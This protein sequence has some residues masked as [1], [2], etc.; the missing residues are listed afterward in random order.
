MRK[1]YSL[2]APLLFI[3]SMLLFSLNA[4][5]TGS[6]S[7]SWGDAKPD[8][9][10]M[11]SG[12]V[13]ATN[14]NV[15]REGG[16]CGKNAS[17]RLEGGCFLNSDK[18]LQNIPI[19]N[20][21]SNINETARV[22]MLAGNDAP[23]FNGHKNRT[24]TPLEKCRVELWHTGD[25]GSGGT[26][27]RNYKVKQTASI[28]HP[29]DKN[30]VSPTNEN[31]GLLYRVNASVRTTDGLADALS[32]SN[33]ITW[34]A[35][36]PTICDFDSTDVNSAWV[37]NNP[38]QGGNKCKVQ[39]S[40]SGNNDLHGPI[41]ATQEW[42]IINTK[43]P[44]LELIAAPSTGKKPY[45]TYS[46]S[47]PSL[48]NNVRV[49]PTEG[50]EDST[51]QGCG[52]PV[53]TAAAGLNKFVFNELT[54]GQSYTCT[55]EVENTNGT[56]ELILPEFKV[57]PSYDGPGGVGGADGTTGTVLW[58]KGGEWQ[59][60]DNRI[61]T[62]LDSTG[63]ANDFKE[64]SG[65]GSASSPFSSLGAAYA[66]VQQGLIA[67]NSI[68]S[69]FIAG[70]AFTTYVDSNGYVLVAS[71]LRGSPPPNSGYPETNS[72]QP[73]NA[74][75]LKREI[76]A[77][78]D[79]EEVRIS[80]LED[81]GR[82]TLD[83]FSKTAKTI[84]KLKLFQTLPNNNESGGWTATLGTNH[85]LG[86][87][88][89]PGTNEGQTER[90]LNQEIY[91]A[92]GIAGGLHW[93][94]SRPNEALTYPNNPGTY[95]DSLDLWVRSTTLPE[96][97]PT[98]GTLAGL[99]I[100]AFENGQAL[101]LSK[102]L[103]MRSLFIVYKNE[104]TSASSTPFMS[105]TGG[106]I[107]GADTASGLTHPSKTGDNVLNGKNYSAG[108]DIGNATTTP[109]PTSYGLFSHILSANAN[110]SGWTLGRDGNFIGRG[111][112][113][114]IAEVIVTD[115]AV[116]KAER[117]IIENY[118]AIKFGLQA[119]L[120]GDS[121]AARYT[122]ADYKY[123][124]GGIGQADDSSSTMR[125]KS[126]IIEMSGS[127]SGTNRFLMWGHNNAP[128]AFQTT[129]VPVAE[130][131]TSRLSRT[132]KVANTG[133]GAID[134]TV[135]LREIPG[136][137]SMC[138]KGGNFVLLVSA[139]GSFANATKVTG[140]FDPSTQTIAFPNVTLGDN[141]YFT[142]GAGGAGAE[143]FVK[144]VASGKKDGSTWANACS[145]DGAFNAPR[146]AG[147]TIKLAKGVY[148]PSSTYN[149]T[150]AITVE[151]GYAGL[152]VGEGADPAANKTIISG[153]VDRNDNTTD[154]EVMYHRE[155]NGNNL[156]RLFNI[157]NVHGV[158]NSVSLDGFTIT[159]MSQFTNHGAAVWQ[160]N[161][162][163]N[164][165]NMRFLGNRARG[166][167]GAI[168]VNGS[169]AQANISNSL[170]RGNAS[171]HGG[172]IA[173]R[174]NAK[175]T[176][177][178]SEFF[179]NQA[180]ILV[181]KDLS[182]TGSAM[183]FGANTN[184]NLANTPPSNNFTV[185]LWVKP[186]GTIA[187]KNVQNTGVEGISGDQRYVFGA[188]HGGANNFGMG[189]SIGTNGI[190][191]A[192]HGDG[193]IP[194]V[195]K[196]LADLS[197]WNHVAIVYTK[198]GSN[199]P[200]AQIYLNGAAVGSSVISS[201]AT[202]FAPVQMGSAASYQHPEGFVGEVDEVRIWNKSLTPA[203]VAN[204]YY[205]TIDSPQTTANLVGYWQFEGNVQDSSSAASSSNGMGL[206]YVNT[207]IIAAGA[208]GWN[209]YE[210]GAIDI[211]DKA[212]VTINSSLFENNS[213]P[214]NNIIAGTYG[215]GGAISLS[216]NGKAQLNA[217]K[218]KLT[219]NDSQFIN[220]NANDG[221]GAIF[222]FPGFASINI[223]RSEFKQN[224]VNRAG[225][226]EAGG[227]ALQ[228]QGSLVNGEGVIQITDSLFE[229]NTSP[230]LGGALYL[231]AYFA[232]DGDGGNDDSY[233]N[234]T[235]KRSLFKD[236]NSAHGGA[237]FSWGFAGN[238]KHPTLIENTTFTGNSSTSYGGAIGAVGGS[239]MSI[240]HATFY[241]NNTA[242]ASGGG[243]IFVRDAGTN[244][245]LQN[246]ILLANVATANAGSGNLRQ[247]SGNITAA[248]NLTGFDGTPRWSATATNSNGVIPAAGVQINQIIDPELRKESGDRT[249]YFGLSVNG[250]QG[251]PAFNKVPMVNC[252]TEDQRRAERK[253][254]STYVSC[255]IG[256]YET[257]KA[258]T[259]GDGVI[260][261]LDNC[262][263]IANP[264]QS[265]IDGDGVGDLCD[266]DIDGDGIANDDDY[267]P[268]ISLHAGLLEGQYRADTD[269]DGIP[270]EC[271]AACVSV[272]MFADPDIDGD[273]IPN[274][275]D[276]CPYVPN[277]DQN[278]M[279][280]DGIGDACD[281]DMDGDGF[282]N[283]VDNCP[284]V[285]NP[286]QAMSGTNELG[287]ACNAVFVTPD[288]RGLGD[289][290]SWSNACAGGS[291]NQLQLEIDKA[292]A[293]NISQMFLAKGVYRPSATINLQPG[294]QIYGGFNGS[295]ERYFYQSNPKQNITVITADK[296]GNDVADG[297][298][299]TQS[300]AG[301]QGSNLS[302]VL[303]AQGH[304]GSQAAVLYGLV[305]TGA[306][307]SSALFI[308]NARVR[309]DNMRFVANRSTVADPNAG[310][311][312]IRFADN[313]K[314]IIENV[315][316][317]ANTSATEGG[318]IRGIGS[319]SQFELIRSTF[320]SN[321]AENSGGA[322]YLNGVQLTADHNNFFANETTTGSG[323][324]IAAQA[325]KQF[326]LS[327]SNFT[328][329]ISNANNT[330]NGGGA[331][332][333][334]G[335][336]PS[337][338]VANSQFVSNSSSQHGGAIRL[339]ASA[340]NTFKLEDS[341]FKENTATVASKEGGAIYIAGTAAANLNIK[342]SSFVDNK[343]AI[344]GAMSIS[345]A[346]NTVNVDATTFA[347]NQS[348]AGP[349]GAIEL[350]QAKLNLNH[351]T[352]VYNK[353]TGGFGGAIRAQTG[354]LNMTN[355]L[356]LGNVGGNGNNINA[357]AN[358]L[359][360]GG[361]NL[362]GFNSQ[363]GIGGSNIAPTHTNSFVS[364][365]SSIGALIKP[366]LLDYGGVYPSIA[367]VS[368][369]EARNAIPNGAAGCETGLN[370]DERGFDRPDRVN[371]NDP[372]QNGDIRNCDIGA[373]EF[374][375]SYRLD[376]FE[377]DGLRPV[378]SGG[379]SFYFCPDG[380]TTTF[381]EI[382]DSF[383]S[384]SIGYWMLGLLIVAGL[385]RAK[386]CQHA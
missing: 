237:I 7:Y 350:K 83:G 364:S 168:L 363:S 147:D 386:G 151:G 328:G 258:D 54:I 15:K 166:L 236:N 336:I 67:G 164:Y 173:V 82:G 99:P 112:T 286:D 102:S 96:H 253:I 32:S 75:I 285:F 300:V 20:G 116:N 175:T 162:V 341:L 71:S 113:G 372:D 311:G 61:T 158:G 146:L 214:S 232:M 317:L 62:W 11:G 104:S 68:Y 202:V 85:F 218:A 373:F 193:N 87:A 381:P 211:S 98:E 106:Y 246:N 128:H 185:E 156:S 299:I 310:G 382:A 376:C 16:S 277:P 169:H 57:V 10:V 124:M 91:H 132:W 47:L 42:N 302:R 270:D 64:A 359:T 222:A 66:A 51:G 366:N 143:Y 31:E 177:D 199:N 370:K 289:C 192:E 120:G 69:F 78:M 316:F 343:A 212:D 73:R 371:P 243:A 256:A 163:V 150:T 81:N 74:S 72:M 303:Q 268:Y 22:T 80:V 76:L 325:T 19:S 327:N 134:L 355:S 283:E 321:I 184:I 5:A 46:S 179:G 242:G 287:D 216:Q 153:D 281:D 225:T 130:S 60:R 318:A 252:L 65:N 97:S 219:V 171:E 50:T 308:D 259:D 208:S 261:A 291:G 358:V 296:D 290:S 122:H 235:I 200:R 378:G 344:A 170:F 56:G 144:P 238:S 305:I 313:T 88:R 40:V 94:P 293:K 324:A 58:L 348:L 224:Q 137:L 26:S 326:L 198:T 196:H 257:Y 129:D 118:L 294:L 312:A 86:N 77:G 24:Y 17:I 133:Q 160:E 176:I 241:A 38:A 1:L 249:A 119:A 4:H 44:R 183:K 301:I 280:G 314:L 117:I 248:Y 36:T 304:G 25:I 8:G 288:G 251:S 3:A 157:A 167:G 383:F 190:Q 255:D 369:S 27:V 148:V 368:N 63:A 92:N 247:Q 136:F 331:L 12:E 227:G 267:F 197:G 279:D 180:L 161:A 89:D 272:G 93:V 205:K 262:P 333:A 367:L 329:N 332:Y 380:G 353:A 275:T 70:E 6:G 141:S 365:A 244:V 374:N 121:G 189:L 297:D 338:R 284:A 342:R 207:S 114:G 209:R 282:A 340:V 55:L 43:V 221:G 306:S 165:T 135:H 307:S 14:V 126:S 274:E 41:V 229:S 360:D 210:G 123:D 271:D 349:S 45:F 182:L 29:G 181:N 159:G 152:D 230:E 139:N 155:I 320:D 21:C 379:A 2:Y 377:E 178:N 265:D 213:V 59:K 140:G 131:V 339:Q 95:A 337:F 264:N 354:E 322:V 233:L 278:D 228:A 203:E 319:N 346:A 154:S 23:V 345:G 110:S 103:S 309:L 334:T 142:L 186:E 269:G 217:N 52:G 109:R 298:G 384:G 149:I 107:H 100:G 90:A 276:N 361:Y 206:T 362:F 9:T 34:T 239:Q 172:A 254:M 351:V 187:P 49:V 111:I 357:P 201:R 263:L 330:D 240:K 204:N 347:N 323:G 215:R 39:I 30:D 188:A 266:W 195:A 13:I 385:L 220:N 295:T 191:V 35:L 245:D 231:A 194:I 101:R 226:Y 84:N 115:N 48:L 335:L 292:K 250:G 33:K 223:N 273:S 125:G 352:M 18:T 79:V 53:R 105:D 356:L 138:A 174:N 28:I 37:R 260:D 108:T 234:T 315:E 127:A 375:D 145:L